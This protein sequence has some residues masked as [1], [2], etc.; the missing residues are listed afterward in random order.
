MCFVWNQSVKTFNNVKICET[1]KI[2]CCCGCDGDR[3]DDAGG[4]PKSSQS[5]TNG[6]DNFVFFPFAIFG[7]MWIYDLIFSWNI[8]DRLIFNVCASA[9]M[10]SGRSRTAETVVLQ[11]QLY[12][13]PNRNNY[14]D[15]VA[16][17][18]SEVHGA[19][20][21]FQCK[22][23][24]CRTE[25][26]IVLWWNLYSYGIPFDSTKLRS[27]IKIILLTIRCFLIS[28][29]HCSYLAFLRFDNK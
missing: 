13:L 1:D 27:G 18:Q 29:G 10:P 23:S 6:R 2:L 4:G 15:F 22:S 12:R 11:N 20:A 17:R 9:P 25:M 14:G 19:I 21:I 28:A 5:A 24:G 3:D 26:R 7:P 16:H 8:Y